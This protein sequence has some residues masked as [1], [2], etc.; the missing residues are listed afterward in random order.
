[1]RVGAGERN[2]QQ[3]GAKNSCLP[4]AEDSPGPRSVATGRQHLRWWSDCGIEEA[5]R[6]E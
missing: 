5:Q 3:L 2:M 4:S 6:R 1:M